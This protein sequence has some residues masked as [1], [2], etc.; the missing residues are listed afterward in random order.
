MTMRCFTGLLAAVLGLQGCS[1]EHAAVQTPALPPLQTLV[2]GAVASDASRGWDGVVTPLQQAVLSA[3]T[4]GRVAEVRVDV[5]DRV[6]RDALLLR[7]TAFEQRAGADAARAQ[8]RAAEASAAEAQSTYHRFEALA[9]RQY[10]S[11]VQLDQMRA[12]RDSTA[13]ARDAARASLAQ[14]DQ[15]AAYTEVRAPFNG[16][17]NARHVEPGET[18]V[19]GQPLLDVHVPGALRIDVQVPQSE[20]AAIRAA[21]HADVVL[22]DGTRIQ[23]VRVVVFPAAD[24][25]THSVQVRLPLPE[26]ATP[27]AP[28]TTATVLF[29][30]AAPAQALRVPTSVL[31]QRSEVSAVYVLSDGR[32][33]LRQLRL[34]RRI[35]D[36]VEVVAGLR[37]GERVVV[38]PVA[39]WSALVAQREAAAH[40]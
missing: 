18:V 35:G 36:D 37:P 34:G 7:I 10:V 9:Q 17:V 1:A 13:A 8:L 25:V 32:L 33:S 40:D 14:F 26:L 27:P 23:A 4:A 15:Q 39:A 21:D 6:E 22:A 30:S 20:A 5:D 12:A 19:P 3:Q 38:D 2:V 29:P 11:R 28:G 24:P 16:I 31:V